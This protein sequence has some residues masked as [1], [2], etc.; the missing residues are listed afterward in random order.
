M[1]FPNILITFLKK[2]IFLITPSRVDIRVIKRMQ[3]K[4]AGPAA[5][6]QDLKAVLEAENKSIVGH[7]MQK[8]CQ[9]DGDAAGEAEEVVEEDEPPRPE[10]KEESSSEGDDDDEAD[11]GKSSDEENAVTAK[12]EP[13]D[14]N[15][16]NR[17]S[18]NTARDQFYETLFRPQVFG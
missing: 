13:A 4:L 16:H 15:V 8:L 12:L 18:G 6:G 7:L 5:S 10:V 3:K 1:K 14:E 11:E 17:W 9:P 2:N